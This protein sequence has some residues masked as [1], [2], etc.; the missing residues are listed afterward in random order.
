VFGTREVIIQQDKR[1]SESIY[2]ELQRQY[3]DQEGIDAWVIKFRF[4]SPVIP[5]WL[6][7]MPSWHY[8]WLKNG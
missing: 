6:I 7:V 8:A 1:F 5:F 4:T 2:W 3:F